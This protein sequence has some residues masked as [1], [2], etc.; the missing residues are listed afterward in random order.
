MDKKQG[1]TPAML[2]AEA[3]GRGLLAGMPAAIE[4]SEKMGQIELVRSTNMPIDLNHG[5]FEKA[6]FK[7][8]KRIDEV[9]QEADLPPGWTREATSHSMHSDILDERVRKRVSVF[10]KA[11]F[12]D[13]RANA[14]LLRRF[15]VQQQWKPGGSDPVCAEVVDC[16]KTIRTRPFPDTDG[17]SQLD[18]YKAQEDAVEALRAE[19]AAERPDYLDPLAYW[20]EP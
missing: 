9:F 11:A 15:S 16:D 20:D 13:R 4:A 18:K 12:Y 17:M 8:G 7:F 10:Y 19:F 3:T 5:L 2:V 6:G 14:H 1:L